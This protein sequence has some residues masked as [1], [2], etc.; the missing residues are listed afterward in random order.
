MATPSGVKYL[1]VVTAVVSSDDNHLAIPPGAAIVV[2]NA[3]GTTGQA[4]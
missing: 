4:R 3:Y 1:V 2:P